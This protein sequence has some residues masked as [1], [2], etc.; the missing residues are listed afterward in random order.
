M[1]RIAFFQDN[2]DVGG[3]QKSLVNLLRNFDYEHF[4]VDLYLS[5][6]KSFWKP[7]F[8]PQLNIKYLRHLPR[9]CSFIPFDIARNMVSLDFG[10]CPEY[11]LAIDFNSY[12]FSCALGALTVPAKRRV[13]WIHNNVSVKLENEWKYRVLW[14]NFKDKFKY[15]DK[16]VAVSRGVIEP[17]M[18]SSGIY[19]AEKF[20]VI[21]NT[22]DTGEIYQKAGEDFDFAPDPDKLNFVALG[23]LCHQKGYDIMLE[24]F[25]KAGRY[26]DDL[27]LY[28]IGDGD[29][30]FALEYQ[31]DSLGLT[32]K[33]TFLGQ[34]TNPFKYMDRMD[35]FVSTSR[36]EGQP[37]NIMEAKAL[38]LPLYCTKNLER[39]SRGLVGREDMLDAVV[40]AQKEP[41]RR[42]DLR[43]YNAEIIDSI[44]ALA[45]EDFRDGPE[46]KR[47]TVNIIALH[48][49]MGGVEKAIVSMANIF[50]RRYEVNLF[51]VYDMPDSPAFPVAEGV[52]ILYLL[53]DTPNREQWKAAL[54]ELRPLRF[55]KESI[56]SV[57]ILIGKRRSVA[58]VIKNIDSGVIITT[59]HEHNLLLSRY[60]SRQVLKIGQLHHDHRFERKYVRGFEKAYG[61]ID[62]MALLTPQLVQE[63]EEMMAGK[64][65]H[66]R[67]V[68]I[69]NFLVRYPERPELREREK[70]VLAAGRLTKVKRFDL[71][72]KQ[73]ARIHPQA[74]D[75][76]LKI[77]GDGEDAAALAAQI[78]E[79]GAEDYILLAG[80]KNGE[81]VEE[82]M[83]KASIFAMSSSSEGFPFVLLEA[84]SCA[85]PILA[86]D[87]RVG[88]GFI[89]HQGED[90]FLAPEGDE[91]AYEERLLEMMAKPE[92]LREMG[93][94]ALL[95]AGEFSREKVAEKWYSVIET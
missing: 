45:E 66:T 88:P 10:D 78:K 48:L 80:R 30:R 36:Y 58:R 23:R 76:K 25:S 7:D 35:A 49:G 85:L 77:L 62:I 52:R 31:R 38:G 95:H 28:I 73:F 37:L 17:F 29:R 1:K 81:Q 12:Q 5:E 42:D 34:Q 44:K 27:H 63:A 39:Y 40:H 57:K 72:I 6:K 92:L 89:V 74:P 61:G 24:L 71:L 41:K 70:T 68:Y 59:R 3:I 53:G 64:N 43:Q 9:I 2:L 94:R 8:P 50:A 54:R 26:R 33:V 15:Y 20:T 60:G 82:E 32:D 19:D 18:V 79:L 4:Q 69:P 75:W 93:R 87:V 55:I 21:Q 47:K 90:G 22:I 16:F 56:R 83:C 51:S 84:Q 86:Y 67:L 46:E 13:M 14:F 11:D 65:S 91:A